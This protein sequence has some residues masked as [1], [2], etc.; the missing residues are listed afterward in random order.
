MGPNEIPADSIHFADAIVVCR[1]ADQVGSRC[2]EDEY[3]KQSAPADYLLIEGRDS[4][5][6]SDQR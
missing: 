1:G 3:K 5:D 4:H 2:E 6:Y